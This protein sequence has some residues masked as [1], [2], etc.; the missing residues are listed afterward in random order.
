MATPRLI[1]GDILQV[2][3]VMT[4]D[5]QTC[6]N[7]LH[8]KVIAPDTTPDRSYFQEM[9][10]ILAALDAGPNTVTGGWLKLATDDCTSRFIQAQ[11]VH[12]NRSPYVREIV[13]QE[14]LEPGPSAPSIVALSG[15]KR[16]D[17]VG[18]GRSGHMQLAGLPASSMENGRWTIA[19]L[20]LAQNYFD[21]LSQDLNYGAGG[22]IRPGIFDS[23]PPTEFAE[24]IGFEAKDELRSMH[25][26]TVG[27]G[28]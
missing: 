28:I 25:R 16:S 24:L 13:G 9:D 4:V 12:P 14:G 6:M 19:Q 10:D 23:K 26:R 21:D 5:E 3:H 17:T 2:V 18:R 15:T 27:L 8:Y 7:V 20:T 11:R 1:E 22:I